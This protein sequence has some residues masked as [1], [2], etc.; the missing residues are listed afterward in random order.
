MLGSVRK[1]GEC[2]KDEK[3]GRERGGEENIRK[4]KEKGFLENGNRKTRKSQEIG[5]I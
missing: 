1:Q 2:R 3:G 4:K 5:K